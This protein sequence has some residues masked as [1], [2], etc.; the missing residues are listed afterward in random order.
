[1][2]TMDLTTFLLNYGLAGVV[3]Y[4]FYTLITN[5]LKELKNEIKELRKTIEILIKT[6]DNYNNK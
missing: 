2:I 4:I 5:D 6:L 1:M 3:I